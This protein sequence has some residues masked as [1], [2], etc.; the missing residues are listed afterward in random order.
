MTCAPGTKA[1]QNKR[2]FDLVPWASFGTV[3]DVLDFGVRKYRIDNWQQ[4]PDSRRRYFSA[5]MRH[6]TAWYE[7]EAVD[8]DSGLP[9]LAHACACILFLLWFDDHGHN[10][11]KE[12]P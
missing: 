8:A 5:C 7:G 4:V 9:H 11:P 1:D 6:L 2:R 10:P 3:V 12:T